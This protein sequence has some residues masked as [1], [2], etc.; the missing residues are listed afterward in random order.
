MSDDQVVDIQY[1]PSG[2]LTDTDHAIIDDLV[3]S[4]NNLGLSTTHDF[5]FRRSLEI[6]IGISIVIAN[7]GALL[8]FFGVTDYFKTR[9]QERAKVDAELAKKKRLGAI[10]AISEAPI[11]EKLSTLR[12]RDIQISIAVHISEI[13][14]DDMVASHFGGLGI[15]GTTIEE[16]AS[17]VEGYI[18][19]VPALFNLIRSELSTTD[20]T[21]GVYTELLPTGD[22]K[23]R[24]LLRGS[25]DMETRELHRDNLI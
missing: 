19:H 7:I 18:F 24:W 8:K 15:R 23:V 1:S 6:P 20:I 12:N 17:Q 21:G 22:L 25:G 10:S 3:T 9:M 13:F 11:I 2:R 16:I 5:V 14:E 4:I